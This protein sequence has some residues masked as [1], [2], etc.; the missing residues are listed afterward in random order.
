MVQKIKVANP[1]V[2]LDG[3]EM[4]RCDLQMLIT[5]GAPD[6]AARYVQSHSWLLCTAS[7]RVIWQ[8]IKDKV[9]SCCIHH[10]VLAVLPVTSDSCRATNV[11]AHPAADCLHI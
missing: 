10:F 3:D 9:S 1:V 2:D 5:S 6:S 11:R 4:T 7:C 8:M